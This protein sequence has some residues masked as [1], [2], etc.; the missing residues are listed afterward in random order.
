MYGSVARGEDHPASDLDI[1]VVSSSEELESAL[2]QIREALRI[3][4]EELGFNPSVAGLTPED[5]ARLSSTGDP[6]WKG[7]KAD[8]LAVFGS[9][10]DEL[11]A[12]TRQKAALEPGS[13]VPTAPRRARR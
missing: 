10:P 8:A 2:Q 12:K 1:A 11:A 4:G 9:R 6:W 3:H 13:T 7:V 5:V